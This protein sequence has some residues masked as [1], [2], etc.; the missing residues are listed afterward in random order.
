[1]KPTDNLKGDNSQNIAPFELNKDLIWSLDSSDI[2]LEGI[3]QFAEDCANIVLS[4]GCA[5]SVR[6]TACASNTARAQDTFEAT[7]LAHATFAFSHSAAI[8]AGINI[9]PEVGQM[10]NN[11]LEG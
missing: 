1:M 11:L 5:D 7:G 9:N 10:L 8:K 4:L 6:A 2:S 3:I